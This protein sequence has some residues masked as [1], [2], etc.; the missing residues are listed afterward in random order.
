MYDTFDE[1]LIAEESLILEHIDDKPS[2]MNVMVSSCEAAPSQYLGENNPFYRKTHTPEDR[3]KI[4]I[5]K[6]GKKLTEKTKQKMSTAKKGKHISENCHMYGK[7]LSKETRQKMSESLKGRTF[8]EETIKKISGNNSKNS[9]LTEI[10]VL[11]IRKLHTN[12][13]IN[14][15]E[16]ANTFSVTS[17]TIGNIIRRKSWK[18]I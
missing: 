3:I 6:T 12:G 4:S 8:S 5:A 7:K 16:L 9:K 10:Q 11:Q 15:T 13:G 17:T 1:L 14:Y 2:C 18:H